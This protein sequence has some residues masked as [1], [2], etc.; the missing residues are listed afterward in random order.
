M[1]M[2]PIYGMLLQMV[3]QRHA[4]KFVERKAKGFMVTRGGGG[5]RR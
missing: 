3:F 2:C 5:V 4:I 1:P